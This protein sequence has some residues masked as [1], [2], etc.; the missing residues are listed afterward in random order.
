MLQRCLDLGAFNV[1]LN[2]LF[3]LWVY[4]C[5]VQAHQFFGVSYIYVSRGAVRGLLFPAMDKLIPFA[6]DLSEGF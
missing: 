4:S 5:V 2:R 3:V 6:S 1:R